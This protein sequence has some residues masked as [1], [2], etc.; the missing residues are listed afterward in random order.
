MSFFESLSTT[1]KQENDVELQLKYLFF[2]Q[3]AHWN[4]WGS[5][6]KLK[7]WDS[8]C[9]EE[10]Q[11]RFQSKVYEKEKS[12]PSSLSWRQVMQHSSFY[13]SK[14]FL[15]IFSNIRSFSFLY[16]FPVSNIFL[17]V[18]EP[19]FVLSMYSLMLHLFSRLTW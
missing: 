3:T 4:C 19:L 9:H 14:P 11:I 12:D 17:S 13:W 7:G 2:F 5:Q 1:N 16:I 8:G 6:T 10:D 15:F 18:N